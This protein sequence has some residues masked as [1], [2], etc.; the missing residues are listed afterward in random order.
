MPAAQ[1]RGW[2]SRIAGA[3]RAALPQACAL[4][5]APAGTALVCAT[6]VACLPTLPAACSCCALPSALG[7]LCGRCLADPPPFDRSW[8]PF[9]Y[10]FPLDRLIQDY[11]YHGA[12]AYAAWFA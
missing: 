5:A 8:A 12:L 4:C 1:Q 2:R 11:K 10:A 7:A 3:M 9:A 6:C